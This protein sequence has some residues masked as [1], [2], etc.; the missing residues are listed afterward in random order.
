MALGGVPLDSQ[1]SRDPISLKPLHGIGEEFPRKQNGTIKGHSGKG[2]RGKCSHHPS[3][4]FPSPGII[5]AVVVS[6]F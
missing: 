2:N 1:N 6:F 5:V 3:Q 4:K